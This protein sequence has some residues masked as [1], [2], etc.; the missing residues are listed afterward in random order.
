VIRKI[1]KGLELIFATGHMFIFWVMTYFL[2]QLSAPTNLREITGFYFS[3]LE[4]ICA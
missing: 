2:L 4:E 1:A 3:I